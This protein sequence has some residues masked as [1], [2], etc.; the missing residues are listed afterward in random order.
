MIM[1]KY[2]RI[3]GHTLSLS[4][5]ADSALWSVSD[6][7]KPFEYVYAGEEVLCAIELVDALP[8]L[9]TQKVYHTDAEGFPRLE[10]DRCA[11]GSWCIGMAPENTLP[12][13]ARLLT[14]S[15]MRKGKLAL[16]AGPGNLRFALDN[17]SMLMFAMASATRGTLEIH[18]SVTICDGRGYAFLGVSGTGKSTHSRLW[19]EHIP[20]SELLNDDNPVIRVENGKAMIYGSPWSGKTPCYRNLGVPLGAVVRLRQSPENHIRQLKPLEAYAAIFSSS[21]AFREIDKLADGIHSTIE[22]LVSLVKMYHLD[23]LP[24]RE[25]AEL[26]HNT[27]AL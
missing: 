17:A 25:A 19:K 3:A 1:E 18:S 23:C 21:S 27:V 15:G 9:Q 20:G 24:D 6:N 14:D 16:C 2:Y 22:Q 12:T 26:C 13:V 4:A 5:A 10:M 8:E 11:D 7:F